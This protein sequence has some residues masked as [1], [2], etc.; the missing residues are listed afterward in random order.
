MATS[1][2]TTARCSHWKCRRT[3]DL[4]HLAHDNPLSGL[5]NRTLFYNT[6]ETALE[7]A[8]ENDWMVAV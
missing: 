5:S 8:T 1:S 6:L 2:R 4:K 7:Q 3:A